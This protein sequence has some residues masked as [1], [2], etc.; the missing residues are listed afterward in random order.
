MK[1]INLNFTELKCAICKSSIK[2]LPSIIPESNP[3]SDLQIKKKKLDE[4]RKNCK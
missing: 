4:F 2:N 1:N 3:M